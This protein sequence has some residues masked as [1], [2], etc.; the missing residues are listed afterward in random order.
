MKRLFLVCLAVLLIMGSLSLTAAAE[1]MKLPAKAIVGVI[2][3]R[4]RIIIPN[5]TT[6]IM[7]GD[8]LIIFTTAENAP[9]I[10]EYFKAE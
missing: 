9:V 7:S 10:R 6:Q 4:N 5:G 1:E 3:R 2:Q 8:N